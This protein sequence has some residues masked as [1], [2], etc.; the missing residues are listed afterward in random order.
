MIR[1]SALSMFAAA[2]VLAGCM[3]YPAPSPGHFDRSWDAALGATADA[4]VQVTN[5]HRGEGRGRITGTKAGAEVRID[6]QPLMD[7]RI[8]V[9]IDAPEVRETNP[10]LTERWLAAYRRRMGP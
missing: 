6:L 9:S 2:L 5:A 8:E 10:T 1:R 7:G 3:S 4:G